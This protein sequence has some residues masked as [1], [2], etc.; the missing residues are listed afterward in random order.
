[1][2]TDLNGSGN[3]HFTPYTNGADLTAFYEGMAVL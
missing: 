3:A 1:M 2:A